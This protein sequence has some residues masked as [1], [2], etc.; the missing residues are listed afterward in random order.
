MTRALSFAISVFAISMVAM[1]CGTVSWAQDA[2]PPGTILPVELNTSLRSDK[3]HSGALVKGRI[4]QDVPLPGGA[5]IR[6]GMQVIG[7]VIDVA[8]GSKPEIALR[9]DALRTGNRQIP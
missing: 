1:L 6:S 4:M 5:K 3:M 8:A 2:I 7:T 9:F